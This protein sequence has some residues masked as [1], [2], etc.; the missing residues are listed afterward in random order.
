[1][2]KPNWQPKQRDGN[3]GRGRD[4]PDPTRDNVIFHPTSNRRPDRPRQD[5]KPPVA[6]QGVKGA[7]RAANLRLLLENAPVPEAM[8]LVAEVPLE[9]LEAMSQGALCPD[10]TAF[11][12]E[13]T[14]KLPGKWLDG[15]NKEVPARTLHLL[16]NPD[17]AELQDDEDFEDGSPAVP[18]VSPA[19][20]QP[21]TEVAAVA[22]AA[23]ALTQATA[24]DPHS[25][26]QGTDDAASAVVEPAALPI[27]TEVA[28]PARET[29]GSAA[30]ALQAL[31]SA[32]RSQAAGK[33]AATASRRAAATAEIQLPLSEVDPPSESG[34][35]ETSAM[36]SPELR[37]Q[38]LAL[39]LQGKGAKSALARVLHAK[40]P[41][42]SAMLSGRKSLDKELCQGMA[43]ALG[44]PDDWFEA[45]RTAADIPAVT[46]QRLAS[47]RDTAANVDTAESGS[48]TAE[49]APAPAADSGTS[50]TAT[51]AAVASSEPSTALA[52]SAE[53]D[54]AFQDAAAQASQQTRRRA[55]GAAQR[56][57]QQLVEPTDLVEESTDAATTAPVRTEVPAPVE[58]EVEPSGQAPAPALST[59]VMASAALV[60][61][62][63]P[64]QA[65]AHA[66]VQQAA[67]QTADIM[68]VYSQPLVIEGGL[69]PITEALIKILVLKARQGALS[70]D[71][72]FNLLG[73]VR[74][75]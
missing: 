15:L 47:L 4:Y 21:V 70:E 73:A 8:A 60:P 41:Y 49:A 1:M 18:V 11:H 24:H 5:N 53:G 29:A 54:A 71:K 58:P 50:A 22:Q 51:P 44:L 64:I 3:R 12:I 65:Q 13:R 36:A 23:P 34:L 6:K 69:A 48:D 68:P 67:Q 45:P 7:L 74:L 38:N 17:Q 40:P 46:L 52:G 27:S 10:E 32:E 59:E 43:R 16:K 61:V 20:A 2:A 56:G 37:Q 66:T 55:R 75:L 35:N 57:G 19:S 42:V 33:R 14:L 30:G 9:R 62:A 25:P 72:A 63:V 31:A 26:A 28:G 39:L